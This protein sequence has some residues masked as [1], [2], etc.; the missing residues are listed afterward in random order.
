MGWTGHKLPDKKWVL[1][2]RGGTN[3]VYIKQ[4]NNSGLPIGEQI[5]IP[6]ELI[7]EL[8]AEDI[9]SE[10]IAQWEDMETNEIL[11]LENE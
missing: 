6:S 11:G 4:C 3:G 7:R 5:D 9:R 2:T 8:V 1:F 10:Q